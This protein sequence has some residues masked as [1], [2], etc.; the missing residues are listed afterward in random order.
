MNQNIIKNTIIVSAGVIFLIAFTAGIYFLKLTLDGKKISLKN[1]M[2]PSATKTAVY[3]DDYLVKEEV[4]KD[5]YQLTDESF[6]QQNSNN[7]ITANP[8]F[9]A[10]ETPECIENSGLSEILNEG[11]Q[12][13]DIETIYLEV[14]DAGQETPEGA[15]LS[16]IDFNSAENAQ[17]AF[18]KDILLPQQSDGFIHNDKIVIMGGSNL[19]DVQKYLNSIKENLN[20]SDN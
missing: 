16:V 18:N 3:P 10:V 2:N 20:I 13:G 15:V 19:E 11:T 6:L 7:C 17:K 5:K 4:Y 14:L 9:F 1:L 12:L 8:G